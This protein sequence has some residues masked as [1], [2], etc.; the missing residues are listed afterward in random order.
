MNNLAFRKRNFSLIKESEPVHL[1]DFR[2][3]RESNTPTP[4]ESNFS[5]VALE[6]YQIPACLLK[7]YSKVIEPKRPTPKR[8]EP[9]AVGKSIPKLVINLDQHQRKGYDETIKLLDELAKK[10]KEL[11]INTSD[12]RVN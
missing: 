5:G 8:E 12:Q 2:S 11:R 4:R 7:D 9:K 6:P 1:N 10:I 3:P